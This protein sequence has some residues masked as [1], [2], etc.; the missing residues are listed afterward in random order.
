MKIKFIIPARGG[1]KR[2]IRKNIAD[3]CGKP[4]ISYAIAACMKS[5]YYDGS[6]LFV[7]TEDDE[8]K[9]VSSQLGASIIDRPHHLSK[10]DVWTQDVLKHAVAIV[11]NEYLDIVVRIQANSPQVTCDKI[12]ECIKKLISFDLWEVFTVDKK[13][14]EDSAIH[15]MRKKCVYQ[16]ALSVFKGVVFADC[17]DIHTAADLEIVKNKMLNRKQQ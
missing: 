15:V 12:D 10:N 16:E 6:N 11:E 2:L 9:K 1:S 17:I 8:I 13:G 7:S 3:L 14:I 4:L 5:E